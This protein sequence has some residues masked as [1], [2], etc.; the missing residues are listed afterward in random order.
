MLMS[1]SRIR[2]FINQPTFQPSAQ[3]F[4]R[5]IIKPFNKA[6]AESSFKFN[7]QLNPPIIQL[8]NNHFI[9]QQ[10]NPSI[11]L[12]KESSIFSTYDISK[13]SNPIFNLQCQPTYQPSKKSI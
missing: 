2:F 4:H 10:L 8:Q 5:P 6:T 13:Q 1:L 7:L 9:V 3:L 11:K 12:A